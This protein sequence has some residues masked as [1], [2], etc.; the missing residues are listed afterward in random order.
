MAF[1][2]PTARARAMTDRVGGQIVP[3]D[4]R[5]TLARVGLS[6]KGVL[7]AALGLLAIQVA[8]GQASTGTVSREGAVDLVASQPFGQTMLVLFTIGLFSLAA[9]Q[10]ILAFTGDPVEGSE[11]KD[12]VKYGAKAAIYATT[13]VT[14]LTIFMGDRRSG[15]SSEDQAA[16]IL[17]GW[18]GGP[19]IVGLLGLGVVALA[20]QQLYRHAW[21]KEFMQRLSIGGRGDL[22]RSIE[23]AG[24]AGYAA[25]GTVL[26]VVGIFF[27]VAAV[28]HDPRE[29]V[30]LSGALQVLSRQAWGTELLWF[31]AVGLLL[32]GGFCFA[33]ARYRRAT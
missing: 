19:W 9:W 23:R 20:C 5:S 4:W 3:K 13:A 2:S 27:L 32:Y 6:A 24:R 14:A 7:Y 12:R 8:K 30:G 17:M 10:A 22:G 15:G 33:E 26:A 1:Q 16:G 29:A 31:V 28:Q 25:R 21:K 11:T 18:P